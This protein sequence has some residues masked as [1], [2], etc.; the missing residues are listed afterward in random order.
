MYY[1]KTNYKLVDKQHHE[2]DVFLPF[3][4][5]YHNFFDSVEEFQNFVFGGW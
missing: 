5:E 4:D 1:I 3:L 2:L